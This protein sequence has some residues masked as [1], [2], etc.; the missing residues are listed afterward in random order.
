[1]HG[2]GYIGGMRTTRRAVATLACTSLLGLGLAGCA[3]GTQAAAGDGSPSPSATSPT[4]GATSSPSGSAGPISA[5]NAAFLDRLKAGMG[6]TGSVHVAMKMTGPASMTAQGDTTYGPDGNDMQ[7]RMQMSGIATGA[8]QMVVV[9]GKAY[10]S[11]PGVTEPGQFFKVDQ[12]N[13]AMAGLD[14]GLS[15]ADSLAAFQAGLQS[16]DD[17]GPDEIGGETLSHYRLHLDA[18]AALS[19]AGQATVPGLPDT[20][21]YDVWLDK[22]DHMRRLTYSLGGTQMTMDMTGWGQQV[23]IVAPDPKDVVD[24]PPGL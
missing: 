22:A 11:M 2:R 10:M 18:K 7:L 15:P 8:I 13:P 4:S 21:V 17:L 12:S 3:G 1:M 14:D 20:L 5:A 9:D 16:V 24:A 19:A 6:Q 23:D